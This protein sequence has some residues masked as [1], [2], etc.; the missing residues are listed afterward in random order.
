MLATWLVVVCYCDALAVIQIASVLFVFS[1]E[2]TGCDFGS[3]LGCVVVQLFWCCLFVF[4]DAL[5][6]SMFFFVLHVVHSVSA[7]VW[8]RWCVLLCGVRLFVVGYLGQL[9]GI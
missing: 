9:F 1:L 3:G 4:R 6:P 7:S 5:P 2:C 8:A